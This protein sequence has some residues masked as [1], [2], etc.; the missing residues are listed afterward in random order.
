MVAPFWPIHFI[1]LIMF[2]DPLNDHSLSLSFSFFD[3][4]LG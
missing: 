1:L 2:L 3:L 4:E